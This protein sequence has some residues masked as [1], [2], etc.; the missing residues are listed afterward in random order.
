MI[1]KDMEVASSMLPLH[2]LAWLSSLEM[3]Y[4]PLKELEWYICLR[5]APDIVWLNWVLY[6]HSG[7][8]TGE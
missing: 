8:T 1:T 3:L 7:F 5:F 6:L 2:S 4:M